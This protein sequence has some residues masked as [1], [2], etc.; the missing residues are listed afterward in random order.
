MHLAT[1]HGLH[2]W[3]KHMF[4]HLG[5]MIL[6]KRDGHMYKIDAYMTD[7]EELIKHLNAKMAKVTEQD[8]KADLQ[9]LL[10]NVLVLKS[11][12]TKLLHG[13]KGGA[14]KKA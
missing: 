11:N 4:T 14:H 9:L 7:I 5:W 12:A 2:G 8:T 3:Y 10:D 6:A 13:S 1:T